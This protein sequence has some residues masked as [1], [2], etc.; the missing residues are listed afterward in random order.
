ME[1]RVGRWLRGCAMGCGAVAVLV[2]L[3]VGVGSFVMQQSFRD[4]I[5]TREELEQVHGP[6]E[7]FTPAPDGTI[8]RERIEAFLRVRRSLQQACRE[9]EESNDRFDALD[10]L[11]DDGEPTGREVG[12]A[13]WGAVKTAFGMGSRMGEFFRTRNAALAE[14]DMGLGEYTYLYVLSGPRDRAFSERVESDLRRMLRNQRTAIDALGEDA[15]VGFRDLLDQE[16]AMLARD[17]ERSPW[18]DGLPPQIEGS[19]APYRDELGALFCPDAFSLELTRNEKFG[20]GIRG[21]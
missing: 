10:E 8:P 3:F 9:L 11:D 6:T 1:K 4:A 13:L 16:I 14:V 18:Q 20:I 12:S 19:L 17:A 15:L 21:D 5:D 7:S 2:L